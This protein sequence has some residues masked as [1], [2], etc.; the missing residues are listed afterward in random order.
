MRGGNVPRNLLF[1]ARTKARFLDRGG[2]PSGP[3]SRAD[4]TVAAPYPLRRPPIFI[5]M[6]CRGEQGG[7]TDELVA[8][9]KPQAD[10]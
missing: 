8:R 5:M 3:A 4:E 2:P 7:S 1:G 9:R 10:T 6:Q